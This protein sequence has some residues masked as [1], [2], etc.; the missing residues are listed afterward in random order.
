MFV[1]ELIAVGSDRVC[2][3]TDE[4]DF[5]L[6]L[7]ECRKW[8][9]QEQSE[10]P[11][12]TRMEIW[13]VLSKRAKMRAMHLLERQ[14]RTEYQ[15]R[16]K[17]EE[18]VYPPSLIEEAI[19]Y[20]KSYHYIDDLRYAQT[21]IACH[22]KTQSRRRMSMTLR[23][24]GVLDEQIN[25]A[26]DEVLEDDSELEAIQTLLGKRY[27]KADWEDKSETLR[28]VRYLCGKGFHYEQVM[29][30]IRIWRQKE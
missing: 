6:Y 8:A 14:G 25:M 20:V 1:I 4:E 7:G 9:I 19:A 15:L 5:M 3:K 28:A 13:S 23:Q 2:V 27:A 30:A 21:Y 12:H 24:R 17:L 18:G 11:E 10:L 22:G 29:Q 26:L 16:K